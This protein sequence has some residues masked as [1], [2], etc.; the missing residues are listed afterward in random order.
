M[1]TLLPGTEVVARN[2]RWTVVLSQPLGSQTLYRLRVAGGALAGRELDVLH[3]FEPIE[4]VRHDLD[5]V[6]AHTLQNWLAYHRAFL[7]EQSLGSGALLAVQPGRLRMEPYQLVPLMRAL[8]LSR[9]RLLLADGVGLGKTVQA[10]IILTEL[11]ARRLAHRILVVAPAGPLLNQWKEELVQ[12]FGLRMEMVDRARIEQVRRSEEL[13]ANPF[14]HLPLAL[15]SPDF[16]KQERVLEQLERTAYDVV[17]IDE[18]H[19]FGDLGTAADRDDTLRRRLAETLARRCDSLLLLTATPHDGNDRS[20]ASLCELLDPSLVDGKGSLRGQQYRAHVVRRLKRHIK[21][22][23]TG[24]PRFRDRVVMPCPVTASD[25]RE[26]AFVK[27]Q[28]KLIVLVAPELRRAFR[29]KQYSEVLAFIALLKRSVSTAYACSRTLSVVAERYNHVLARDAEEQESRR[30]RLR[31]LRDYQRRLDRFGGLSEEEEQDQEQLQ[32]EDLAQRLAAMQREVRS[33]STRTARTAHVTEKL[34]ELVEL[35]QDAASQDPKLERLVEEVK[36]IRAEE[37]GAS[38]LIYTEYLD[39]QRV[40]ADALTK[41]GLGEI[42]TLSGTSAAREDAESGRHPDR[43]AVTDRFQNEPGL[44]LVSTDASAE[45]LNLQRH[46]HHLIHLELPFNPNRLEQRNGRIDRYGQTLDPIVRYLYLRGTFEERI[47]FRLIAK[48]E[49]QRAALTFVPNTLGLTTSTDASLERLLKPLIAEEGALFHYEPVSPTLIAAAEETGE[50][51]GTR[52]LLG[53][54]ERSLKGYERATHTVAWLGDEGLNAEARLNAEADRARTLG[55]ASGGVDLVAFVRDA[56]KLQKGE[57]RQVEPGVFQ[58][59][60]PPAWTH[61]LDGLPG[62]DSAAHTLL[63]T[64]D[65]EVDRDSR[66]RVL[67]YLGRAHPIVHRALEQ[68]RS[69]SYGAGA[70]ALDPRVSAVDADVKESELLLTFVGRIASR[71][72]RE[73]ERVLAVR[74]AR[75]GGTQCLAE[76]A[77]WLPLADP[78]RAIS[79]KGVWEAHFQSWPVGILDEA[80]ADASRCF[81]PLADAFRKERIGGLQLEKESLDSWIRQSARDLAPT[82]EAPQQPNLFEQMSERATGHEPQATSP[83]S[84]LIRGTN[85]SQVPSWQHEKDPVRRLEGLEKDEE[86]PPSRRAEAHAALTLYERRRTDLEDRMALSDPEVIPIGMLMLVPGDRHVRCPIL[87]CRR[88]V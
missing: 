78:S 53:E 18:A 50:D 13:G 14:D 60:I 27:M 9:V 79:T 33:G 29:E 84:A 39:S 41:A 42:L 66:G 74:V 54:I 31:S 12:R 86:Q 45:G 70:M 44:I 16:L 24:A 4:P 21:D 64:T 73:M 51:E 49:R 65:V 6:R 61:G 80:R 23:V 85:D 28:R 72:G 47:L 57:W 62:Y 48:Y 43:A 26:P 36:A 19:H 2:L 40:A 30:Q 69:L 10:G 35:A 67:G 75:G 56:L 3:P 5:P 77:E 7:L 87:F 68:V 38:I 11:L 20:F 76:A 52:D 46:C 34:D 88:A 25:E 83:R 8:K 55:E 17:V 59:S 32:A 82:A 63:L 58:L 15:A 37:P 1:Q 22:P 81:V 71:A